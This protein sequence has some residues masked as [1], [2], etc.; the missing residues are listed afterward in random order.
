MSAYGPLLPHLTPPD[1][2]AAG[3]CLR[4]H[5]CG[6]YCW[7]RPLAQGGD[8]YSN[9]YPTLAEAANDARRRVGAAVVDVGQMALFET[10]TV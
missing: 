5:I 3:F 7:W 2:L 9:A 1:I 6:G 8:S 4:E 10:E